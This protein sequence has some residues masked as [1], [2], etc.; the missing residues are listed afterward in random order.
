MI[1]ATPSSKFSLKVSGITS[2]KKKNEMLPK[3]KELKINFEALG[4]QLLD[5][6]EELREDGIRADAEHTM[7]RK[8][9]GR[10]DTPA[11]AARTR[12]SEAK[13]GRARRTLGRI[14]THGN[15]VISFS[16]KL[17]E[18]FQGQAQG[19]QGHE[20]AQTRQTEVQQRQEGEKP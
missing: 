13:N 8:A 5:R 12:K 6:K 20:R 17:A 19:P 2:A 1:I 4:Q 11:A 3:A 9:H 15:K 18:R 7:V 14:E 16:F 10:A